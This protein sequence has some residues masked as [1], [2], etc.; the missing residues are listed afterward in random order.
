MW[1]PVLREPNGVLDGEGESQS[2]P[3]DTQANDGG[4]D[5]LPAVRPVMSCTARTSHAC[6]QSF[7]VQT[8]TCSCGDG[9]QFQMTVFAT[10]SAMIM[11]FCT[12][13]CRRCASCFFQVLSTW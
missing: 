8:R 11:M 5:D 4:Q 9:L 2:R 7:L 10:F 3:P 12:T 1:G 6:Q 13:F